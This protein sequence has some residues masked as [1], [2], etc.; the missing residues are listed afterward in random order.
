ME[1]TDK[2][3]FLIN[4]I[5]L[6]SYWRG[7]RDLIQVHPRGYMH[8]TPY[9]PQDGSPGSVPTLPPHISK[10]RAFMDDTVLA[11]EDW[12]PL[13]M[14][15]RLGWTICEEED[16]QWTHR[17]ARPRKP[18]FLGVVPEAV[19]DKVPAFFFVLS[20]TVLSDSLQPHGLQ[21]TRLLCPCYFP[22][23]NTGWGH[24]SLLQGIFPRQGLNPSLSRLLLWQ[25]DSLPL[26]PP[27]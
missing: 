24:H 7:N 20:C 25:T 5:N 1:K 13:R 15:C 10:E 14:L 19:T 27:G 4:K 2:Y 11:H 6:P 17:K 23:K 21:P 9:M 26:A 22:G 18:R 12:P 3:R 8:R 16:G